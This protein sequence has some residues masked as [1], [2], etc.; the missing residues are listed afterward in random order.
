MTNV[1]GEREAPTWVE[2]LRVEIPKIVFTFCVEISLEGNQRR[3]IHFCLLAE[4]E[5]T[6]EMEQTSQSK[7]YGQNMSKA[8]GHIDTCTYIY[9]YILSIYYYIQYIYIYI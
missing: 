6:E 1:A 7:M 4:Y 8:E 5:R 9:I 3:C 2:N